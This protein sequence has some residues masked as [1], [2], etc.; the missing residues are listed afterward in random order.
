MKDQDCVDSAKATHIE[1]GKR[2]KKGE[3][4]IVDD[5]NNGTG[6]AML[7]MLF[8]SGTANCLLIKQ[9]SSNDYC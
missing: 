1:G 7:V 8:I 4:Q 3:K 2:K 6:N 9:T 5:N